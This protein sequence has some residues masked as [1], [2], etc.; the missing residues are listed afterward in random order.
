MADTRKETCFLHGRQVTQA[1]E[2]WLVWSRTSPRHPLQK[3][4]RFWL[5]NSPRAQQPMRAC[6]L[7]RCV[8]TTSV[9]SMTEDW[10]PSDSEVVPL[11]SSPASAALGEPSGAFSGLRAVVAG[12]TG[13]TG[14]AIVARLAAEGVPIRALVRD[15]A[16][17]VRPRCMQAGSCA[18]WCPGGGRGGGWGARRQHAAFGPRRQARLMAPGRRR[19]FRRARDAAAALGCLLHDAKLWSY[20]VIVVASRRALMIRAA[21][22]TRPKSSRYTL[23]CGFEPLQA[24]GASHGCMGFVRL[25]QCVA[26]RLTLRACACGVV[27]NGWGP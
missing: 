25:L 11:T 6:M 24:S 27:P 14:R 21:I 26:A 2:R 4:R 19:A 20:N 12:A 13:G 9:T 15:P 22:A 10:T 1:N 3:A 5:V 8:P 23:V 18:P 16:A 17:A 7:T